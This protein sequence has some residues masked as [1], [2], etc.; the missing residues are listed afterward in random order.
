MRTVAAACKTI[1][2]RLAFDQLSLTGLLGVAEKEVSFSRLESVRTVRV[3]GT[4]RDYGILSPPNTRL[5]FRLKLGSRPYFETRVGFLSQ[6]EEIFPGAEFAVILESGSSEK[7]LFK[8]EIPAK[9]E[10]WRKVSIDLRRWAG[11]EI[12][13]VL[14]T[15][16]STDHSQP[17]P[18]VWNAPRLLEKRPVQDRASR[19]MD[20]VRKLGRRGIKHTFLAAMRG[21]LAIEDQKSLYQFWVERHDL[22]AADLQAISKSLAG[23]SYAPKISII[24]PV[25]NTDPQWLRSCIESVRHQLYP[26]W[27][28]C[29]ADDASTEGH[30]SEILKEYSGLDPRI[31]VGFS[32]ANQGTSQASNRALEMAGG[33]F[34]GLLDHD[35]GL[36]PDALYE[37]VKLFQHHPEADVVYSDEDKL[38]AD[39]LS[40]EPFFK[41]DWSPEY[42]LSCMYTGH[43]TVYRKQL[44]DEAGGFRVGYDGSQDYDL[45]LRVVE[46][47]GNIF[48]IPRIL[49]H[50][51]KAAGSAAGST[52]AKPYAYVAAKKALSDH[53]ERK[54]VKGDLVDGQWHGHY[55]VRYRVNSTDPVAVL[56]SVPERSAD[57]RNCIDS[58]RARTTHSAHE[59]MVLAEPETAS[60]A[61]RRN[62]AAKQAN[63]EYL[64]F[65]DGDTRVITPEWLEAMLEFSQQAEIGVV[66]AKL[67]STDGRI[68]HAG[69][70]L[71]L[72][73]DRLA[74]ETLAGFPADTG[75]HFG[76]VGDVRNCS[77][78]SGSCMMVR[79]DVFE[80]VGGFD[81][82][83]PS[84]FVDLDFCLRVR[85]K[86]LRI[87]WTPY[88]KL[89]QYGA[90]VPYVPRAAEIDFMK[91]RWGSTLDQDP[92]YNP[93]LTRDREDFGIGL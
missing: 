84:C 70:V 71:G 56:I 28:L 79:R 22:G 49:Y 4:H 18:A 40:S 78:V 83:V 38:D 43:F 50:W 10:H 63:S 44:V 35:D 62:L 27:E 33:D 74:G 45:M 3:P 88:A 58:I 51:R 52:G 69:T 25:Y 81:E 67:L 5:S 11:Q 65:I 6:T 17:V 77:A 37:V 21:Q 60:E 16:L 2:E 26:N 19:L 93:N 13:L 15:C 75:Y 14:Q 32:N 8:E 64:V 73:T 57:L 91:R 39:G 41:P 29:L 59:T 55:R 89:Y 48:H 46:R 42:L 12:V 92:Y 68:L 76:L 86:Q 82:E 53:L 47:T 30:V 36:T 80:L 87:V 20:D 7:T 23:F 1:H 90:S 66:G 72:G 31:K 24:T 61:G 34:I 54:R 9:I 85:Q